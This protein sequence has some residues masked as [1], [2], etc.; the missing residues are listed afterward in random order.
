MSKITTENKEYTLVFN[1]KALVNLEEQGINMMNQEDFKLSDFAKY[2][3][4]G[5]QK[6]HKGIDFDAVAEIIDEVGFETISK[7]LEESMSNSFG[8]K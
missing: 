7:A 8:K 4:A 6:H 5:L 1:Y 2:L 3:V